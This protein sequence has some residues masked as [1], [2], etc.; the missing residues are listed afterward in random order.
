MTR[1]DTVLDLDP[2]VRAVTTLLANVA[3]GHLA[4][5]TPCAEFTVA[6]LL[7]HFMG[8]SV[9]F[10]MAATKSTGAD[11]GDDLP[12]ASAGP[13]ASSGANLEP[14]WRQRLPQRLSELAAAWR[15]PSASEGTT[16]IGGISLPAATAGGFARNELLLHG[17]DLARATGQP[18]DCVPEVVEA[19]LRFTAG[20]VDQGFPAYGP[21]VAVADDAP[22][23]DRLVA[24]AGRD[25]SW[26]G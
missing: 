11:G 4:A 17:W 25:P 16:E 26:T 9:A 6:D 1:S 5:R 19:S 3:D 8:L 12:A 24:L 18:F 10:R 15:N 7:D 2:A 21:P 20:V 14:A 22:P 13:A 23:W